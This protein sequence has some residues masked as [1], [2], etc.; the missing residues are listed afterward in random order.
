MKIYL[1]RHGET[2]YNRDNLGLGL[3]IARIIAEGHGGS[4]HGENIEGGVRF[5]VELPAA[6]ASKL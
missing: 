4:I 3:N 6:A 2:S 1:V 5:L